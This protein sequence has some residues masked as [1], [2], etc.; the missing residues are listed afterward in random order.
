MITSF[1]A[2]LVM[3]GMS[4]STPPMIPTPNEIADRF[5]GSMIAEEDFR[6]TYTIRF[7]PMM[8]WAE[9]QDPPPEKSRPDGEIQFRTVNSW[10][11][12][13]R[14]R[15]DIELIETMRPGHRAEVNRRHLWDGRYQYDFMKQSLAVSRVA[16]GAVTGP[17]A[18][19]GLFDQILGRY[20]IR[21]D[22]DGDIR[23]GRTI[24]TTLVD[25]L[26]MHRFSLP[27]ADRTV[28]T[29][30][31]DWEP[32]F[33]LREFRMDVNADQGIRN[34]G[35]FIIDEWMELGGRT[36]P[37]QAR[38]IGASYNMPN[39]EGE[40]VDNY[41]E[42]ERQELER[43]DSAGVPDDFFQPNWHVGQRVLDEE[44]KLSFQIGERR[45]RIDGVVYELAEPL[46]AHPG[47]DLKALLASAVK[48]DSGP[49]GRAPMAS[50]VR[51]EGPPAPWWVIV[52]WA[53]VA[54]GLMLLGGIVVLQWRRARRKVVA[55]GGGE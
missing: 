47:D 36:I 19:G 50:M 29:I 44:L 6:T 33:R 34:Y 32:T 9:G 26:L 21:T 18:V 13:E 2:T 49:G 38:F 3:L 35:R 27:E 4:A 11:L 55:G 53:A 41:V 10:Y 31:A 20:P 46:M 7:R 37:K 52:A 22:L 30:V 17:S 24:E 23:Q 42:Y 28:I 43:I 48:L 16:P 39:H 40:W 1:A 15:H 12:G 8:T 45:I 14:C 54:G 25:G 51:V 5:F